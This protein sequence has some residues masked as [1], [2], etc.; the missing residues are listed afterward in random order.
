[1]TNRCTW[2]GRFIG[3]KHDC[4]NRIEARLIEEDLHDL[5]LA[6]KKGQRAERV[7]RDLWRVTS[8]TP[9]QYYAVQR[10]GRQLWCTCKGYSVRKHCSHSALVRN[11]ALRLR[12]PSPH[13]TNQLILGT[14]WAKGAYEYTV[15][16]V[17]LKYEPQA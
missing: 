13:R 8:S 9:D 1:M 16:H 7:A 11:A 4:P 10:Q 3:T 6:A 12:I 2:C 17:E 5:E 15:K 14:D